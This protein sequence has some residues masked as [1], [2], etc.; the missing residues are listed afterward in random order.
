MHMTCAQTR[1]WLTTFLPLI[2]DTPD[3]RELVVAPPFTAISTMAEV[4]S[5]SRVEISSQNVHWEAQGAFTG[6]ILSY[7]AYGTHVCALYL[8]ATCQPDE[9]HVYDVYH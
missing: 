2:A 5:G 3:D 6:E 1:D 7:A 9:I 8:P 4:S